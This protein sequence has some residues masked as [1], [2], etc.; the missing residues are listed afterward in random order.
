[1]SRPHATHYHEAMITKRGKILA[2]A[3]NSIGSRSK[4]SGYSDMTIH[5]ERAVVKKLGDI[6]Q[7]RGAT[8]Y[9]YRLN[10]SGDLLNSKPCHD[11]D[12]FLNKCMREYGLSKVI[13]STDP[14]TEVNE[15]VKSEK[16][17]HTRK[18]VKKH[19]L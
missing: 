9:V 19:V 8:L 4:G 13:W 7:L 14:T 2:V 15:S 17:E 3:R 16:K 5:A 6:S 10:N 18:N 1:M 11:C 12:L